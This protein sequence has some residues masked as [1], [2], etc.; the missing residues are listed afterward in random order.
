MGQDCILYI[1]PSK[2][3]EENLTIQVTITRAPFL[4]GEIQRPCYTH[5]LNISGRLLC[6]CT[7][8]TSNSWRNIASD[9]LVGF[10]SLSLH[11]TT[12]DF[13]WFFPPLLAT[14]IPEMEQRETTSYELE[15][16]LNLIVDFVKYCHDLTQ[17]S[18]Y[19]N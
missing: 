5:F 13:K 4:V 2:S 7:Y 3:W 17:W 19:I 10:F 6:C 18:A 15:N 12:F 8:L 1:L 16:L 14:K 11:F 9:F